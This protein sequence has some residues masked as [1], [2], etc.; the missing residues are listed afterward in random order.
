MMQENKISQIAI[1][2]GMW[3][4]KYSTNYANKTKGMNVSPPGNNT[5]VT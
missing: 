1:A 3:E 4:L 5:A 2:D